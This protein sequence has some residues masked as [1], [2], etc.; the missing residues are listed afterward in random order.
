[1]YDQ[2]KVDDFI[3]RAEILAKSVDKDKAFNIIVDEIDKC[4]D[5]YLNEYISA[6]N[7]IR[8]EKV[9]DWI[10]VNSHRITKIGAS[11]G[12]LVASSYFSWQRADKWLTNGRPLS[13][14]SLDAILFCTTVGERLNQSPWMRK[15]KPKLIDNPRPEIIAN[16]LQDYL[17]TDSVPRTKTT[18][19]KIIENIFDAQQ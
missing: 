11:W 13:L 10:E 2:E 16:R 19:Q 12:H 9:F 8:S 1:M 15:I 6:L 5:K 4:E 3:L 18:V 17:K 7:F 14:I